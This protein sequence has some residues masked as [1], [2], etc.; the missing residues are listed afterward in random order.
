MASWAELLIRAEP[1]AH[2]AQLYGDDD[3]LLARNVS[4]YLEEGLHRGDGLVVV[5]TSEHT[6]AIARH[7]VEEESTALADA[8]R[9]GRMRWLPA[10]ETL[11]KL[12]VDGKLDEAAF[13]AVIGEVLASARAASNTG[14]V[15]AFGEM[16]SLLWEAGREEE[17]RRLEAL[18][19]GTLAEYACS[20][21][22][23][24]RLDL[25]SREAAAT[26]IAPIVCSH[27]HLLAGVGTLLF[28]G[29]SPN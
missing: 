29:R 28:S 10:G 2:L 24:Y 4:R 6:A 17:T 9:T 23:A 3:R 25:F 27:D 1:G 12:R 18:W 22:C 11:E 26:D 21:Y 16:V 13:R 7:L 5:A 8:E 14:Q 15:R 19:N 20:L